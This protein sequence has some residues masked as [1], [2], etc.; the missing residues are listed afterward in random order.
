VLAPRLLERWLRTHG[1]D[2]VAARLAEQLGVPVD[3]S[4]PE[5]ELWRALL[6][7]RRLS[8]VVLSSADVPVQEGRARLRL[9]EVELLELA[10]VGQ[11]HRPRVEAQAGTFRAILDEDQLDELLELPPLL[12]RVRLQSEGLRVE[13]VAGLPFPAEVQV[14][15]GRLVVVP[16]SP[17]LLRLLPQPQMVLGLPELPLGARI[18]RLQLRDGHVEATGPLDPDQLA[19]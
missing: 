1:L 6:L 18:T 11:R 12:A 3:I 13:T 8:H 10:F 14:R 17:Q 9:V 4:V 2:R 19:T 16:R 7:D 5:V 15:D